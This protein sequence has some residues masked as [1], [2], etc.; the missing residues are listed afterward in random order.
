VVQRQLDCYNRRQLDEF[1][2][3]F[4][5]DAQLFELGGTAPT[6]SGKVEI[7]ERYRDLFDRSP[8]LICKLVKRVA[9]GRVVV[10]HEYITGRLG[11]PD[12]FECLAVYEV[13][14]SLIRRVHFART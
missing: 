9:V 4:A 1:C 7:R 2:G 8:Q 13:V 11:S 14:D 6:Y 3:C 5:D 10:D 12:V